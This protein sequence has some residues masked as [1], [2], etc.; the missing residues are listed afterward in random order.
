MVPS[1]TLSTSPSPN[2]LAVTILQLRSVSNCL[3]ISSIVLT[4]LMF[5]IIISL[6]PL[7]QLN[8]PPV[9]LFHTVHGLDIPWPFVVPHPTALTSSSKLSNRES[10]LKCSLRS[11]Q[12]QKQLESSAG[13]E[14]WTF[15]I[16]ESTPLVRGG[17]QRHCCSLFEWCRM[18][19][20]C[21][22]ASWWVASL[23]WWVVMGEEKLH[24][25]L[26]CLFYSSTIQM[27][28]YVFCLPLIL[29]SW[30]KSGFLTQH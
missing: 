12:L 10:N 19:V 22:V 29:D 16:W 1:C 23:P 25:C 18:T 6:N 20:C 30:G 15:S 13:S 26:G 17:Q 7:P 24:F 27:M 4:F 14:S 28:L 21:S 3:T 5:Y 11:P 9:D 2:L 8:H